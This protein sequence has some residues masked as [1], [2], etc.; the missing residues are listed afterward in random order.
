M[1]RIKEVLVLHHSHLDVGYTH[2]QPILIEMQKKYIDEALQMCALT[3]D[4]SEVNRFRWT[5]E[6]SYPVLKWLETANSSQID[7]FKY[8]LKNGQMSV[9]ASYMH[10]T[11]LCSAEQIAKMLYPIRQLRSQFDIEIKTAI[12]HDVNGQ[13]W[14]YSQL[15]LDA[16]VEFLIMGI[17]I[18]F[19]GVPLTRPNAFQWETPDHRRLLTFNGEHYS[20][21]SQI[22]NVNAKNT[23]IMA[24]GLDQYLKKIDANPDYPFDFVYLT[25]TNLP[26]YDNNPPDRELA[27]LI[28]TWN[29]E[30]REQTIS[31]VTPEQ[32]YA[33]VREQALKLPVH[34]GD[35]TDYWNF[36]SG[37]AAKEV[38]LSRR[39]KQGMKAVELLDAFQPEADASYVSIKKQAWDQIHLYDEHT[40]GAF[41]SISEPDNLSVDIQHI[42]KKH[43]AYQANSL[44]G[45]L[46]N[47]QM[48]KLAINSLQSEEPEG[49]LLFNSTSVPV[50]HDIQIPSS[51]RSAGRHLS[52]DRMRH[53]LMNNE[54]SHPGKSYGTVELPPFT[55]RTI[56]FKDLKETPWSESIEINQGTIE[57]TGEGPWRREVTTQLGQVVTPYHRCSFDPLTGR[58]TSLFDTLQDWEMLDTSSPWTLFQFVQET[59]DPIYY[60]NTRNAIFPRDIEKGN[61]SVSVWNHD[62]KAKRQSYSKLES[63]SVERNANSA[64]LIM[65]W[66]APGV[67][68]LEQRFTFFSYRADIE[69]KVSF[70]KK[71]ITTPE[72]IYFVT[73]LNLQTWN[74]HYDTAGKLVELDAQQLPGVCR[75]YITVDKCVSVYGGSHGVTM[76][77]QDAPLVQVGDFNFGK[78]QKSISKVEKPLLLAWPMNNYWD[79]NFQARQPGYNSY[80]YSLST[81][82]TFNPAAVIANTDRAIAQIYSIPVIDCK[83]GQEKTLINIDS[84]NVKVFD[85]KPAEEGPGIIL[86]L[87]NSIDHISDINISFPNR[88][89]KAAFRTNA[90]E[91]CLNDLQV[92]SSERLEIRLEANQL[93]H[94]LV[95]FL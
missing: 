79:T 35:W 24:E 4:W 29:A 75:D 18:H 34:A 25:A 23:N 66:D 1:S 85:V 15:L 12:H 81:F 74:C 76:S 92:V 36:G 70:Y 65:R 8:Y 28:K 78:E 82:Q 68:Q 43:Y 44:T 73:P 14:S 80:T 88:K 64:T 17:N 58:I 3:E 26:L 32:L 89:L 46:L 2:A 39:T 54:T 55:W 56:L 69:I 21:F 22:C 90:L 93:L 84:E 61:N 5:C 45:Y 95:I 20:L 49:I 52:A 30:Q 41:N 6:S 48:E 71:D 63:C 31:F 10:T 38:K 11:P 83:I 27:G 53:V 9:S 13:P 47:T 72:G 57:M 16:G 59:V 86:R 87:S 19:G 50:T 51:F 91:E 94:I 33:R 60:P 40:W 37:S 7:L 42:H 67:E 77:C 62:W